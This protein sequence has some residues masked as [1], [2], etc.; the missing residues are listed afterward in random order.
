MKKFNIRKFVLLL[1]DVF[2][3]T[4]SGVM[5]N[6]FFALTKRT[7]WFH[8]EASGN[9]FY[10]ILIDILTCEL[11]MLLFGSYARLWRY[12]NIRD[13]LMCGAAM[14]LGFGMGYG[15]L[16]LIKMEPRKIFFLLFY[17]KTII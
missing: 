3:I 11:M 1:A 17:I 12:F 16:L 2:I 8:V 13:Y 7:E 10:F 14:T 5:L 4:I 15:V 9:L 6:Y